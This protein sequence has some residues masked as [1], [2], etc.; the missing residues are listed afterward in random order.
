ME[1]KRSHD[2][3]FRSIF[4]RP[5]HLQGL[6]ENAL[7]PTV[8][9]T[10]DFTTLKVEPGTWIDRNHR[11]HM[12]DIAASVELIKERGR[13][14]PLHVYTLIEHKSYRD[15]AALL[16][17]L[18]YMVQVWISEMR[19]ASVR[20]LTPIIPVLV[21]HGPDGG[22]ATT[23]TD[24]FGK[25]LPEALIPYLVTFQTEI[26]DLGRLEHPPT[27][28]DP[29]SR[30]A[31]WMMRTVRR[32][33][34]ETLIQLQ[35]VF[36][37]AEDQLYEDEY[38]SLFLYLLETSELSTEVL[39]DKIEATIHQRRIKEGLLTTAEQLIKK[40]FEDGEQIGIEK[41]EIAGRY[42]ERQDLARE[43]IAAGEAIEKV[44]RYTHLSLDELRKLEEG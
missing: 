42:R 25:H 7:P 44:S 33:I 4:G 5:E 32:G 34:D 12:S 29:V 38:R 22:I 8:V 39:H 19:L 23:F 17:L 11:E 9:Q 20:Q 15:P 13:N 3:F 28:G 10:L 6:L 30:A 1:I 43:M 40:G 36:K 35:V 27:S 21:Y 24:L 37:D 26:M 41:G 31:L 2:R 18:R 16:Q 14:G